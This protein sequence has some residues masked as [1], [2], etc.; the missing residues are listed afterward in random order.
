[1]GPLLLFLTTLIWGTAF[2][3]QKI[4]GNSLGPFAITCFR[5]ILGGGFLLACVFIRNY[6]KKG[7]PPQEGT[8]PSIKAGILCGV[9]L[10]VAMV[11]QQIGIQYTTPGICAFLTTNYVLFVPMIVAVL[12][13]RLPRPAVL[14]C[15]AASLVGTYFICIARSDADGFSGIGRG[16]LWTLACAFLFAV[17]MLV[18]NH[19]APKTDVLVLSCTQLVTGAVL[20]APFLLMPSEFALLGNLSVS[21]LP[22]VYL[23]VFSSG[24]AYTLQNFG[25]ARTPPAIAAVILSLESVFGALSGYVV[26]GDAMTVRQFAGC[27]LVFA[28]AVAAQFADRRV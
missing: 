25:Q 2:L 7:Q 22:L 21:I 6:R 9:A 12:T 5:N 17:Q 14:A 23:G 20:G 10:F 18:V 24:I 11:V 26:L 15:V 13:H 1:M 28:A 3:A 19:Y 27:A 8:V 4:G 16:E